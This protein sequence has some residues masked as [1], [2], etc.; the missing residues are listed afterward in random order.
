MRGEALR[1]F[2]SIHHFSYWILFAV[3][4]CNEWRKWQIN[5]FT[6]FVNAERGF[7]MRSHCSA[8]EIDSRANLWSNE[9]AP[10]CGSIYIW[11]LS[12]NQCLYCGNSHRFGYTVVHV[13]LWKLWLCTFASL[14]SYWSQY[15]GYKPMIHIRIHGKALS[16]L[17]IF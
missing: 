12:M 17:F 14:R 1:T 9:R 15:S 13:N 16:F 6:G 3:V 2:R 5:V 8:I 7:G 10:C 11:H 4:V